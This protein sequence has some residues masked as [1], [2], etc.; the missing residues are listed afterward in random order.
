MPTLVS[1]SIKRPIYINL[2]FQGP[3]TDSIKKGEE[4][5]DTE[6]AE[7]S[8]FVRP[9]L[10]RIPV[11]NGDTAKSIWPAVENENVKYEF[12]SSETST[13]G[14][15]MAWWKYSKGS[16]EGETPEFPI[17]FSDHGPG[18]GVQT[19]GIF[20]GVYDHM[21]STF[22]ALKNDHR[23][24]ERR[25]QRVIT[26]IQMRVTG[27][28]VAPDA[29]I[30]SYPLPLID[31]LSK[32]VALELCNPGIDY[33]ARQY[34]TLTAQ[35][36]T[37]ISSYPEIINALKELRNRLIEQLPE[38]W[39]EIQFLVPGVAQ[40]KIVAMPASS[41]EYED[42][43]NNG[44]LIKRQENQPYITANPNL[45]QPLLTGLNGYGGDVGLGYYQVFP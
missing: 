12:G 25:I 5:L 11:I 38:D 42:F 32:R 43:E 17:V 39:K 2:G 3:F 28:Y 26:L 18:T 33:W 34:K 40:R 27:T 13:E 35:G 36:P 1:S 4:L 45:S 29:E 7:L 30:T 24:G 23:F 37:E 9:L 10:S 44:K 16:E 6:G 41:T 14:E 21:P 31:Y 8:F 20:D 15:Y 22:D 19:G